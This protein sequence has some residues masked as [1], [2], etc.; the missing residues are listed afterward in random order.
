MRREWRCRPG[1]IWDVI[2]SF[3]MD[4]TRILHSCEFVQVYHIT[5]PTVISI[6]CGILL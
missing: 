1:S 4:F 3:G 2:V 6:V 5:I